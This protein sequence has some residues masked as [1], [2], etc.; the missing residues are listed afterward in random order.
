VS[1][2]KHEYHLS[3]GDD[4]KLFGTSW[5]NDNLD[6]GYPS[7]ESSWDVAY[8]TRQQA[9]E[10]TGGTHTGANGCQVVVYLD[11]KRVDPAGVELPALA[12]RARP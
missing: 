1:I 3:T 6:R 9:L 2:A 5:T 11:G 12:R 10:R 4:G 8:A 7:E